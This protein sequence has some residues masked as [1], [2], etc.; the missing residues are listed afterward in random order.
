MTYAESTVSGVSLAEEHRR[1]VAGTRPDYLRPLL[2]AGVKRQTIAA[3]APAAARI[4][5]SGTTYQLDPP[6]GIAFLI[7]VRVCSPVSPEAADPA[8]AV[9]VAA[10][11]DIVACHPRHLG[12]CASPMPDD[13]IAH[14]WPSGDA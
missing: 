2:A 14:L 6:G 8:A 7:P 5:V 1:A 13:P 10:I 4:T 11:V 3:V 12:R 9:S